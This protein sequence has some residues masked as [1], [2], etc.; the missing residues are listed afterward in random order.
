VLQ[1]AHGYC[2]LGVLCDLFAKKEIGYW[3]PYLAGSA[4]DHP[5]SRLFQ[6]PSITEEAQQTMAP[7]YILDKAGVPRNTATVLATRNDAGQ[8]FAQIAD[9]IEENL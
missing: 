4:S 8:S 6:P 5:T 1:D 9:Y 3:N 2:C 7:N